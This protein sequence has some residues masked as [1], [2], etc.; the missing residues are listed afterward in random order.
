MFDLGTNAASAHKMLIRA[1][2][3][4]FS[5]HLIYI[6]YSLEGFFFFWLIEVFLLQ[7][8]VSAEM[9]GLLYGANGAEFTTFLLSNAANSSGMFV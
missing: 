8:C 9:I 4:F 7:S 1:D 5:S 3:G 6:W 2:G